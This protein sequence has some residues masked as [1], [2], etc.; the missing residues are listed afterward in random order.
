VVVR[1]G[2][3]TA[4]G[5]V[6]STPI[7]AGAVRV[8][9]HGRYLMPGLAEMHA[10]VPGEDDPAVGEI[11]A[12]YALTGATTL[13][14]MLGTPF[15]FELRRRIEAGEMLGPTLFTVAPPFNASSVTGPED[16]RNKVREYHARGYDQLKMF[17][18]ESRASYDAVAETA[19]AV[20]IRFAGHVPENIG[21]LHAIEMGQSI[22]HLDGYLQ[23]SDGDPERMDELARRSREAGI[24]NAPTLDVWKTLV[25]MR[26]P[27][28]L[29][30]RPELAY[31]P[32]TL[33]DDWRERTAV[34]SRG[35]ILR[36]ALV[37]LG[38]ERSPAEIAGL[39]DRMLAALYRA[40]ARLLLG[41]DSPQLYSVPGFSI[42]REMR[43]MTAAGL[44]PQQ[45]LTAATRQPARYFGAEQELGTVAAGQR[46][47]L[48]LLEANPL[49]DL[50]NIARRAGVMVNGRWLP[51]ADIRARL[52][53]I[54]AAYR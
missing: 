5:S 15:Q 4:I 7:P 28:E 3:I 27:E 48:L 45:I 47:D 37:S 50:S 44:T 54:A 19:R 40:G 34:L 32:R 33:V 43:S 31:L 35:G 1:D 17:G 6:A 2:R 14:A 24:W 25:G 20:G 9:G 8:E 11:M 49:A 26:R 13:R 18:T 22:E 41:A 23:A 53:R 52:E 42:H 29:D 39:R 21:L 51:E 16:A 30:E 38:I 36:N 12:L 46:A 10:H